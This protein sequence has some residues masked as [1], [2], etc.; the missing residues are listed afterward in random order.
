[1]EEAAI[2]FHSEVTMMIMQPPIQPKKQPV[3]LTLTL[4]LIIKECRQKL[5][6]S[7]EELANRACL[8]R[9]YISNI[10]QGE[11][12][13]SLTTLTHLATALNVECSTLMQ[14]VEQRSLWAVRKA[15]WPAQEETSE[16]S[17]N[18]GNSQ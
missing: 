13:P 10:E 1:V 18:A 17:F 9:T 6:L 3:A 4:G 15:E 7:Q 5:G 11:R 16:R 8:H 14:M 2:E 12:N